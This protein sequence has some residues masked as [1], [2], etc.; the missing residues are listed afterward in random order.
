ML[1][2][3]LESRRPGTVRSNTTETCEKNKVDGFNELVQV[4]KAAA[5]VVEEPAAVLQT[6]KID[7]RL[8]I[9]KTLTGILPRVE[10]EFSEREMV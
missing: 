2:N 9:K 1:M 10:I 5:A 3:S 4:E 7:N 6:S 8:K